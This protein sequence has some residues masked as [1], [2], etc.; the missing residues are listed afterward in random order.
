MKKSISTDRKCLSSIWAIV[1]VGELCASY[2][3]NLIGM[4]F[5]IIDYKLGMTEYLNRG[6]GDFALRI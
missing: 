4:L 2:Y 6:G 3:S 1:I 5:V